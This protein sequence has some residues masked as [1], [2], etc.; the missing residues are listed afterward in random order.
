MQTVP[1]L[2]LCH[3]VEKVGR[4]CMRNCVPLGLV[5]LAAKS[6][7]NLCLRNLLDCRHPHPGMHSW[8]VLCLGSWLRMH[9]GLPDLTAATLWGCCQLWGSTEASVMHLYKCY[10]LVYR[11][12]LATQ[13]G[14]RYGTFWNDTAA[15][16]LCDR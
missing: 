1:S 10:M 4:R 16:G 11:Q 12:R 6:E 8:T 14:S 13:S 3:T 5:R 9:H 7:E 15:A 2:N